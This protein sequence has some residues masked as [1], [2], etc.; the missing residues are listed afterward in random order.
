MKCYML[1]NFLQDNA[2]MECSVIPGL[3][4]R[5]V[6][7]RGPGPFRWWCVVGS[8]VWFPRSP[9]LTLLSSF[10]PFTRRSTASFRP[11]WCWLF[12]DYDVKYLLAYRNSV[13][14]KKAQIH[15]NSF[16]V[17]GW[18][19]ILFLA[20]NMGLFMFSVINRRNLTGEA[21]WSNVV[22]GAGAG[23]SVSPRTCSSWAAL[24]NSF[25]CS[26]PMCTSPWYI[27][28]DEGKSD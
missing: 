22:I 26:W 16:L 9:A 2:I 21:F 1:F 13:V 4:L 17:P 8:V 27:N 23:T 7:V 24:R 28:L 15:S 20:P 11:W 14:K 10:P 3:H 19:S 12:N 25:N 5:L 18:A 6:Q